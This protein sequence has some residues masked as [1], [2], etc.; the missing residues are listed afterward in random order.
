MRERF[1]GKHG[2]IVGRDRSKVVYSGY[3]V[4][5]M[6]KGVNIEFIQSP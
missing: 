1:H 3:V 6:S 2:I 5:Y 4:Q